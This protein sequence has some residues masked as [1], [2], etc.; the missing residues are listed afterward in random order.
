MGSTP[1][2]SIPDL[3]AERTVPLTFLPSATHRCDSA[4]PMKPLQPVTN[5]RLGLTTTGNPTY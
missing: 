4:L 1:S 3:D 5:S 2:G